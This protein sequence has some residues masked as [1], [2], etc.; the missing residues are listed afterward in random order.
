MNYRI[1]AI[2]KTASNDTCKANTWKLATYLECYLL[3]IPK[4]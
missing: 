2:K 4:R 3:L 1:R